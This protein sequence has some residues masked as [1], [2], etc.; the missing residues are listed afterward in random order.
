MNKFKIA[1]LALAMAMCCTACGKE[2]TK[3][4]M[5]GH[6]YTDETVIT[7]DGNKW[8]YSTDNI[9]DKT[10]Y[11]GMAVKVVFDDNG[12]ENNITDD[13]ILGLVYIGEAK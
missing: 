5:N 7:S 11:N 2:H 9:S 1:T 8:D 10:P 12:T 6:Y 13:I 4:T 3:Y